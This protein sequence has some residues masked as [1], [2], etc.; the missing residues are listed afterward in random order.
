MLQQRQI[1]TAVAG[2]CAL[3][4]ASA[5]NA[6][7]G[8]RAGD[9]DIDFSGNVNGFYT[10][11]DCDDGPSP[12]GGL[13]CVGDNDPASVRSGLLPSAFVISAKTNQMGFDIGVTFGFYPGI[14][15]S[16]EGARGANSGGNPV[17]LGTSGIDM[18][19][20][21]LTFGQKSWGTIKIGRDIGI[22]SSDAILNDM[23]LLG[24]GSTGGNAAPGNTSLGRIGLGYIY[25]DWIP[26]IT[27]ISP[28][29]GGLQL[30]LGVMQPFEADAFA[31]VPGPGGVGTVPISGI[32]TG[33]ETPQFQGKLTWDLKGRGLNTRLWAGFVHQE[34]D[35]EGP[36]EVSF[37]GTGFDVGARLGLGIFE[38][39]GYYYTGEGIGTTGLFLDAVSLDGSERDSDGGYIQGTVKFGKTKFGVSYGV[40]NLDQ[41]GVDP[42]ILVDSNESL[43][44]GVYHALTKSLN[45]VAEYIKTESEAHNG[46][47]T[48]EDTI[49][50]GAILFF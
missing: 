4:G 38:V 29:W 21:F 32:A 1:C 43:V 18:R 27:Y 47:E 19:Q 50:V 6:A 10:W 49:A 17:A 36:G 30:H 35:A 31:F 5:A 25:T 11:A 42:G 20:N 24:V 46:I 3:L 23:T 7:I 13:A 8:F 22:F 44:F 2:A 16:V 9:W 28:D 12:A 48:E 33:H 26:Q 37:D 14:N 39:V 15:S 41:A 34:H 40:S 45:L